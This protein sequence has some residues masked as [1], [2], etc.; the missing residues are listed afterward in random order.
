MRSFV[1]IV[2]LAWCLGGDAAATPKRPARKQKPPATEP[3][4][5]GKVTVV[6][7]MGEG[8]PQ[9]TEATGKRWLLT[10]DLRAELLQTDGH[11]LKVWGSEGEKKLLLPTIKVTRY[12]LLDVGGGQRPLVG[13]LRQ[14]RDQ[15]LVLEQEAR[16]LPITGSAPFLK[17]LGERVGCKIWI[18]G[19]LE[20]G[21]LNA[22]KFGWLSC[23]PMKPLKPKKETGT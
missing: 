20:G 6:R 11:T 2:G 8:E 9:L 5:E 1:A 10:G 14:V 12:E 13:T 18:V 23:R 7:G 16:T 15:G 3:A 17:R 21:A 4:R 19:D 22:Y